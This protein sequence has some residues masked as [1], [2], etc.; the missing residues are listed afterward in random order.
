MENIKKLN[1]IINT[2]NEDELFYKTICEK[3]IHT[4]SKEMLLEIDNKILHIYIQDEYI[5][6]KC[7]GKIN[8]N[9]YQKY[10]DPNFEVYHYKFY[11][12]LYFAVI[13]DEITYDLNDLEL[14]DD[15]NKWNFYITF[16]ELRKIG[17][18]F[19][20]KDHYP[21]IEKYAISKENIEN[22]FEHFSLEELDEFEKSLHLYYNTNQIEFDEDSG[23]LISKEDFNIDILRLSCGLTNYQDFIQ[24]YTVKEPSQF[25]LLLPTVIKYFK[26]NNMETLKNY[27]EDKDEGL[28][29]ISDLY[30]DL[31][32][33]LNIKYENIYTYEKEPGEYTTVIDFDTKT[34]IAMDTKSSNGLEV[35]SSNL[36]FIFSEYEKWSEKQKENEIE[37]DY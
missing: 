6:L 29:H 7:D 10:L 35:V 36:T 8:K 33:E 23:T 11:Q 5:D 4:M 24:E 31:M 20:V 26:E 9:N 19:M 13:K 17:Y 28:Y 34:S 18:G 1:E 37:F 30:K 14:F 15:D 25:D 12:D 27:G 2:V 32:I 3:Y 16:D 21:L 22:F